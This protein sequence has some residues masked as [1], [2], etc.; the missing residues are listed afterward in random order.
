[1]LI[2]LIRNDFFTGTMNKRC[3]H[4]YMYLYF[5]QGQVWYLHSMY[6]I[7]VLMYLL[8]SCSFYIIV[9]EYY[10]EKKTCIEPVQY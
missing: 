10:L 9:I 5:N 1:M 8:V 4:I 3:L 6:V 2:Y 7:L